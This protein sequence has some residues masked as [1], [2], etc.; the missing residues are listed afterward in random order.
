MILT[1]R[2]ASREE[3]VWLSSRLRP[4]DRREIETA[5][6]RSAETLLPA[7]FDIS[8]E[9][10]SIRFTTDGQPDA[11]PVAIFGVAPHTR[12]PHIGVPWFL[13]TEGVRRG[14]G[15][16][17]REANFWLDSWTDKYSGGLHNIVDERNTLHRRWLAY[18][19]FTFGETIILHGHPFIHFF[20]TFK[21]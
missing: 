11:D 6:G 5:S 4:E 7:S 3:A 8:D 1:M 18:T 10:Y 20:R 15:A 9:V 13:S 21:E 16:L 17:I 2:P 12:H 14:S 19:G